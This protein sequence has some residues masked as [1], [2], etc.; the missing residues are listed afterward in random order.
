MRKRRHPRRERRKTCSGGEICEAPEEY[1]IRPQD[2]VDRRLETSRISPDNSCRA[3]TKDISALMNDVQARGIDSHGI[4]QD[5][6]REGLSKYITSPQ[7]RL[8]VTRR[9]Q[10][11]RLCDGEVVRPGA[12]S[13]PAT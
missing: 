6:F 1:R 9:S 5:P 7:S 8:T 3:R 11:P 4:W 13:V 12:Q 2:L 10:P